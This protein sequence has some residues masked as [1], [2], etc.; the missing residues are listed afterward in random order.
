M[1][2]NCD[3]CGWPKD[4]CCCEP[5]S[6]NVAHYCG[7]CGGTHE[8][9]GARVDCV[10]H[11]KLRAIAAERQMNV[12]KQFEAEGNGDH[13]SYTVAWER[14]GMM[15]LSDPFG[16]ENAARSY[17]CFRRAE[18]SRKT[19]VLRKHQRPCEVG[20]MVTNEKSIEEWPFK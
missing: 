2:A 6:S 10:L 9:S 5:P 16:D 4:A 12:A 8:P 14:G 17:A 18:G 15:L 20:A 3:E 13:I 7:E 1:S 11:W 19:E